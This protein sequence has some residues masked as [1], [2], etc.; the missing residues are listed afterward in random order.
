MTSLHS[1]ASTRPSLRLAFLQTAFAATALGALSACGGGGG[2]TPSPPPPTSTVAT[3][4]IA[5]PRYGAQAIVTIS[6]TN[7]DSSGL[8]VSSSTC[9]GMTRLTSGQTTSSATLAYYGCTIAGALSGT[10]AIASNGTV[11]SSPTY[12]V[13]APIVRLAVTNGQGVN[14][15]I[16]I[17]LFGTTAPLTVVN[18]LSYVNS[19]FYDGLI[20]HRYSPN[21]VF[22]GGGYGPSQNG[23]LPAPK[24]TNP[25]IAYEAG[26]GKNL[27][28]TVAMAR[29]TGLNTATSQ[30]FIN[31]LDN[32]NLDNPGSPYAVFGSLPAS[33][34][35]VVQTMMAATCNPDLNDLPPSDCLPTPNIVITSA[36]QI[37]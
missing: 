30:F 6:G 37:Q 13:P 24:A 14:G 7:L 25:P 36:T 1:S 27:Q 5:A 34:Q 35:A 15:N 29:Q 12:T 23:I 18:F 22:Q 28:W 11:L 31:L 17:N 2:G 9:L 33:S 16:D 3:A 26:G 10:V 32:A 4:S 8:S 19:T 21:F 20:F